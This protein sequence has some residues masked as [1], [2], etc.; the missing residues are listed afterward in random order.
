MQST[1][2]YRTSRVGAEGVVL[3]REVSKYNLFALTLHFLARLG[4]GMDTNTSAGAP[5][6]L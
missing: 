2:V 4:Y 5:R 3:G 1:L 6:R